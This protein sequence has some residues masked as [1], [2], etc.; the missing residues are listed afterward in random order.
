MM[1]RGVGAILGAALLVAAASA[2]AQAGARTPAGRAI[3]PGWVP[4]PGGDSQEAVAFFRLEGRRG[5]LVTA[6]SM[7]VHF[8][9]LLESR[10]A[11]R[12]TRELFDCA[13]RKATRLEFVEYT[14]PNASGSVL[15][16]RKYETHSWAGIPEGSAHDA[17]LIMAC[18]AP[19]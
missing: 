19:K 11:S 7:E 9:K 10:P 14:G 18:G 5:H 1:K 2:G 16:G 12:I 8:G 6:S 13:T 15:A 17:I 3:P 4:V